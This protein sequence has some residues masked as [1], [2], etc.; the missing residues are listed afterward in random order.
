MTAGR[1]LWRVVLL[2]VLVGRAGL[3]DGRGQAPA[4][5]AQP[6]AADLSVPSDLKPLLAPAQSEM[7]LVTL[8]YGTIAPPSWAT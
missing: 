7:R 5:Q 3:D 4:A 6:V 2:A 1:R 8:L